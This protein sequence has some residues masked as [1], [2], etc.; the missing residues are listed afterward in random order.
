MSFK[1]LLVH[2]DGSKHAEARV[3][4]AVSLAERFSAHLSGLYAA[5]PTGMS[6]LIA[7]Q[8]PPEM[9][10][11]ME[12]RAAQQREGAEAL[13]KKHTAKM[14][15]KTL[16]I[17]G[18]GDDRAKIVA[19]AA[20]DS[21]LT[22]LGQVDPDEVGRGV[23]FDLPEQVA[24][25]SGRPA[26]VIP[27]AW[28]SRNFGEQVLVAWNASP[29]AARAV[30]DALPLLVDSKRVVI[31]TINAKSGEEVPSSGIVRHLKRHG[32]AAEAHPIVAD[33]IK[34]SD[35]ILS[36]ASD[37]SASLIVMGVY[38][39]SRLRELVLGGVSRDMFQRM[40]VPILVAH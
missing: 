21:D 1:D 29:Q 20:R 3:R 23:S 11:D 2:V 8:F 32:V 27:Y 13:F 34:T 24:M 35:M 37:E 22:I 26:L 5:L 14:K 31:L 38:G 30:N 39:H 28:D 7:D 10:E 17:E 18:V 15:D 19:L 4:F 40:T 16:W 33:D 36:R 25:A 12:A 6:P 9:V